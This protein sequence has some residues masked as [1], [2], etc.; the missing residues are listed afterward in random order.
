MFALSAAQIA[1]SVGPYPFTR[2]I[3]DHVSR[4]ALDIASPTR[5]IVLTPGMLDGL[6]SLTKDGVKQ[7]TLT[8]ILLIA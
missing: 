8:L 5:I 4:S 7:T 6:M 3:W 1:L 2:L